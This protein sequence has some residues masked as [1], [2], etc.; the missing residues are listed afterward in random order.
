MFGKMKTAKE[1]LK[2]IAGMS[3]EE[4]AAL[5][6]ALGA[7]EETAAS[8]S[9]G[10]TPEEV[11]EE[12]HDDEASEAPAEEAAEEET[13][14]DAAEESAEENAEG[15]ADDG[16][17]EAAPAD[18]PA[19]ESATEEAPPEEDPVAA[20]AARFDAMASG[21]ETRIKALEDF[22]QQVKGED[23]KEKGDL[24]LQRVEEARSAAT[25]SYA[26]LCKRIG[27]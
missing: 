27:V 19:E 14:E 11:A 6:E 13:T 16:A 4:K 24:G 17:E 7:S 15:T 23:E 3:D 20:L 18:P 12:T 25:E 9:T 10:E 22:M 21:Y 1:I 5:L 2:L 26:E 8:D